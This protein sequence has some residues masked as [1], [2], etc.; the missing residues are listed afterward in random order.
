MTTSL[1]EAFEDMARDVPALGDVDR[2][3]RARQT[4][5]LRI[6]TFVA[7]G[8]VAALVLLVV[9]GGGLLTSTRHLPP[10]VPRP[11]S[12]AWPSSVDLDPLPAGPL[13]PTRCRRGPRSRSSCRSPSPATGRC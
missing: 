7:V 6:R 4:R 2:A 11:T 5:Q 1:H 3:I 12:H 10:V 9:W 13:P 8:A